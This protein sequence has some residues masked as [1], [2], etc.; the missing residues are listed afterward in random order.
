MLDATQSEDASSTETATDTSGA[1]AATDNS[2]S[3]VEDAEF[4]ASLESCIRESMVTGKVDFEEIA[5]KMCISRTHL[6]RKVK[7]ITGGTTSD[8]VLNIRISTAKELLRS[9]SLPVW[10][11]AEKCGINDP[12]YFSTL[13]K[14]A[15][16][17]SPGQYRSET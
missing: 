10:E 7:S 13:F 4:M 2:P 8:L 11:I 9:T 3:R 1:E 17:K 16:G 14:K 12:A 6:N 5:S 15:V